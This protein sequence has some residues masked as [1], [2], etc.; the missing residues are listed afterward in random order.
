MLDPRRLEPVPLLGDAMTRTAFTLTDEAGIWE[1]PFKRPAW[2]EAIVVPVDLRGRRLL[3]RPL[4]IVSAPCHEVTGWFRTAADRA[5]TSS[6]LPAIEGEAC[7][8]RGAAALCCRTA[9]WRLR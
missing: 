2:D 8:G 4:K 1:A 7:P 9:D 6:A 3:M 5:S